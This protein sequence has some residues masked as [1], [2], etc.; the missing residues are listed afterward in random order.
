MAGQQPALHSHFLP[1]PST[2]RSP[3]KHS[4]NAPGTLKGWLMPGAHP[5]PQGAG[6]PTQVPSLGWGVLRQLPLVTTCLEGAI[7]WLRSSQFMT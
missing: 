7:V 1:P 2:C 4:I 6:G 5:A 3:G